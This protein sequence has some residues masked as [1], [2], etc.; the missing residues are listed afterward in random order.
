MSWA[1]CGKNEKTGQNMGY[2]WD[3]KC[4]KRGCGADIH[5]G[6]SYVCGSMH[7]GGTY[8]CG[9]YFCEKHLAFL[10]FHDREHETVQLCDKC[11]ASLEKALLEDGWTDEDDGWKGPPDAEPTISA[12]RPSVGTGAK[13]ENPPTKGEG[14]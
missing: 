7:E 3:S 6:L 8:G 14:R 10:F 12:L 4:H 1:D 5:R 13:S 9:Y 11:Y 2:G